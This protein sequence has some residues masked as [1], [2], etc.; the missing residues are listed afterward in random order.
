MFNLRT[1]LRT[2]A[3]RGFQSS[4]EGVSNSSKLSFN[5]IFFILGAVGI[6]SLVTSDQDIETT[7]PNP[8]E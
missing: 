8:N 5:L 2:P 6:S 7:Q 4:G 3:S 1:P